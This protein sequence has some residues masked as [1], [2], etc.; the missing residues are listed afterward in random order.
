MQRLT[1][2]LSI[3]CACASA[4]FAQTTPT[5]ATP[6]AP[7]T[8]AQEAITTPFV[9]LPGLLSAECVNNDNGSY[10][11]ITVHGDPAGPR[12]NTIT[13]D[14]MVRGNVIPEWGLHLIDVSEAMGNLLDIVGLQSAAFLAPAPKK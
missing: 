2:V 7:A 13:G 11:A 4:T 12:T 6:P 10:L 5:P 9:S 8:P 14:V 3:F 1:I